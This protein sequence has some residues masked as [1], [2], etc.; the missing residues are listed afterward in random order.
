[1]DLPICNH[2]QLH[3][4]CLQG[5]IRATDATTDQETA[6]IVSRYEQTVLADL[7]QHGLLPPK[8]PLVDHDPSVD[9]LVLAGV[10]HIHYHRKTLLP[11]RSEVY[12]YTRTL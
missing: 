10:I 1:M 4:I 8:E 3:K 11:C 9:M 7:Q 2:L 6:R 5:C 12:E